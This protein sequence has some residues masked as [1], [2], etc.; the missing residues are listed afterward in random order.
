MNRLEEFRAVV[1]TVRERRKLPPMPQQACAIQRTPFMTKAVALAQELFKMHAFVDANAHDYSNPNRH[2][3][4]LAS[5]MT[6]TERGAIDEKGRAFTRR[7]AN[8][9]AQLGACVSEASGKRKRAPTPSLQRHRRLLIKDLQRQLQ[10]LAAR[11][12][13]QRKQR[14]QAEGGAT[15]ALAERHREAASSLQARQA[16]A[17]RRRQQ[18]RQR[19]ARGTGTDADGTGADK[20]RRSGGAAAAPAPTMPSAL[21]AKEYEEE[22]ALAEENFALQAQL[23]GAVMDVRRVEEQVAQVANLFSVFSNEV[24]AQH[25]MVDNLEEEARDSKESVTKG[26]EELEKNRKQASF[27]ALFTTAFLYG[28]G[29]LLLFV[30]WYLP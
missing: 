4:S 30:H 11:F 25:E 21:G 5:S 29:L 17:D 22:E 12:E 23:E 8:E 2:I 6:D 15:P 28:A 20:G 9:I 3:P 7:C 26:N 27:V 24:M 13:Q 19:Q 18:L 1:R 10:E 14:L 16:R